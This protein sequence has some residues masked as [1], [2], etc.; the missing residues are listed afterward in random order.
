MV[1]NTIKSITSES[2]ANFMAGG[3]R[4][5]V[6]GAGDAYNKVPIVRRAVDMVADASSTVPMG[7][8]DNADNRRDWEDIFITPINEIMRRASQMIDVFGFVVIEKV[9][10][11][12][13]RRVV[14]LRV[15]NSANI[16][17]MYTGHKAGVPML[18]FMQSG[19]GAETTTFTSDEVIYI[20]EFNPIDDILPGR[21]RVQVAIES[22]RL[23]HYQTAYA[24][25][26][27]EKG[28]M[29]T[30]NVSVP[31]SMM[32]TNAINSRRC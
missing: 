8:Y 30:L 14:D 26:F 3:N 6:T 32:T 2:F 19:E 22:A 15:L 9:K 4:T 16:S 5:S 25:S 23:M 18:R 11:S 29:N 13:G 12:S 31:P 10:T 20:A 24:A 7:I 28:A 21:S 27:F 17:I 1:L